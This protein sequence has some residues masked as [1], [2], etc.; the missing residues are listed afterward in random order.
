MKK[1]AKTETRHLVAS[2]DAKTTVCGR[3]ID[4]VLLWAKKGAPG[5]ND[6]VC[7]R[8]MALKAGNAPAVKE[9]AKREKARKPES[10]KAGKRQPALLILGDRMPTTIEVMFKKIQTVAKINTNGTIDVLL[11]N[12]IQTFNSPSRAGKAVA[13]REI[14][15]WNFWSA[16]LENGA[17]V[18]LDA[19]RKVVVA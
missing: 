17:L 7:R 6:G 11:D 15:G 2:S 8:C 16:R 4:K 14:D 13:G 1:G 3:P 18:K 12:G 19:L 5:E 9:V 10:Q